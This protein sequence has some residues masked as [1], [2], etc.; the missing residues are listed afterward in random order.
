MLWGKIIFHRNITKRC[1]SCFRPKFNDYKSIPLI[2]PLLNHRMLGKEHFETNINE[3][4]VLELLESMT[5]QPVPISKYKYHNFKMMT[6]GKILSPPSDLDTNLTN[7]INELTMK[8]YPRD[9][10][11]RIDEIL[12]EI[13]NTV[14]EK[15]SEEDYL[16]V[17]F[18]FH[19]TSNLRMQF[20][21]LDIMSNKT[22]I[23][24]TIDFDNLLI[25]KNTRPTMYKFLIE[26]LENLQNRGI[27][28]N[29]NTWYYLF[30]VFENPEPK[31]RM[32]KMM[33]EY[34]ID[35]KPILSTLVSL[36]PYYSPEQLIE[37]YK[38][39]GYDGKLSDLTQPLFNQL[40]QTYINDGRLQEIWDL[41]EGDPKLKKFFTPSLFVHI[42][43]HLLENNQLGFAF[44]LSELFYRQYNS[45]R[46]FS[47]S[48][49]ESMILN[50][51]LPN[52]AYFSNWLSLTRVVIPTLNKS[53]RVFIN[54]K[55]LSR[56]HDFCTLHNISDNFKIRKAKELK[57]SNMIQRDLVW[58][59]GKPKFILLDNTPEFIEAAKAVN[60]FH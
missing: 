50:N 41:L 58:K 10:K 27:L 60:Q 11:R 8:V 18:Y 4:T 47:R 20:E 48:I 15:M 55:T 9:E 1:F 29:N 32:I 6:T 16:N 40:A 26:R 35:I 23:P 25:S 36:L 57:L 39:N 19:R 56:L 33:K 31:H 2:S 38:E 7:Y 51:Y 12:T 43:T 22:E 13:I 21:T 54:D 24:Q 53:K 5:E 52:A 45:S 42:A 49:L 46:K 34:E 37:L 17:V 59:D 3:D 28:A 14:P 44:A 30:N